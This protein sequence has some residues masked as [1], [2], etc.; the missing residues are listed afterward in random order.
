MGDLP[1]HLAAINRNQINVQELAVAASLAADPELV[2]QAMCMDPL[3]SMVCT[4][5]EIRAMTSE[6]IEAHREF[7]PESFSG[8]SL[9]AKPI[10][11]S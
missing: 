5:D 3:T 4:L 7:L 11:Y 10:L 8:K 1:L 2:F 9:A 6:L